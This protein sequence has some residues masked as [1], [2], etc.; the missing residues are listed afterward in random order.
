MGV[1]TIISVL[2]IKNGLSLSNTP[3]NPT[4]SY[5]IVSGP[6]SSE[7]SKAEELEDVEPNE[8]QTSINDD[9]LAYNGV[10]TQTTPQANQTNINKYTKP[11]F[12][13]IYKT[14]SIIN[15][16]S[17][18]P[19]G[20]RLLQFNMLSVFTNKEIFETAQVNP[21]VIKW[22]IQSSY[23][24][25]TF[26]TEG[27]NVSNQSF[28]V[29]PS[30]CSSTSFTIVVEVSDSNG[31]KAE[32]TVTESSNESCPRP[33]E[34]LPVLE[35]FSPTA[36]QTYYNVPEAYP[37]EMYPRHCPYYVDI[38]L[39]GRITDPLYGQIPDEDLSWS[40]NSGSESAYGNNFNYRFCGHWDTPYTY[41]V[42]LSYAITTNHIVDK[43][44]SIT[45]LSP[46]ED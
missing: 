43:R 39:S 6:V 42:V 10:N 14:G 8:S 40:I 29:P 19:D 4:L 18:F 34:L 5:P 16:N 35:I 31:Q 33:T 3:D 24:P 27:N 45:I 26:L 36:G 2:C 15:V 7:S 1:I 46:K 41:T 25:R 30:A 22:F 13:N 38:Y 44:V 12:A 23:L 17:S 9:S 32:G 11:L 28:N 21:G 20:S 37:Y